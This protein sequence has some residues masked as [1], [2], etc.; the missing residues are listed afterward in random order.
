MKESEGHFLHTINREGVE[1]PAMVRATKTRKQKKRVFNWTFRWCSSDMTKYSGEKQADSLTM[2]SRHNRTRSDDAVETTPMT[3]V[4]TSPESTSAS[5]HAVY[6]FRM[7]Q[8]NSVLRSKVMLV[9]G[10]IVMQEDV[11]LWVRRCRI[12]A[13]TSGVV[14]S[15][16]VIAV[17]VAVIAVIR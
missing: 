1:W 13:V 8:S 12:A 2:I 7:S 3:P 10:L 15:F 6:S 4:S 17:V 9:D 5:V 11:D 14:L 16:L